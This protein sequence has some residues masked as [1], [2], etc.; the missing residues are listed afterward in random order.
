MMPTSNINSYDAVDLDTIVEHAIED[1]AEPEPYFITDNEKKI[2]AA[3]RK[4]TKSIL[5]HSKPHIGE[6]EMFFLMEKHAGELLDT[7]CD[8][9][10]DYIKNGM[11]LGAHLLLQL[12]TL[13]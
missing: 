3:L 9:S 8:A 4:Y 10:H 13:S 2:M 1:A 11:K 7:F 5:E 6:E 12:T